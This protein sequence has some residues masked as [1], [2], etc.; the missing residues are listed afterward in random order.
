VPLTVA[1][2]TNLAVQRALLAL[3]ALITASCAAS[4]ALTGSPEP[5]EEQ[6]A[7]NPYSPWGRPG[8]AAP[9]T[10]TDSPAVPRANL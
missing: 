6:T 3:A 5:V 8:N 4:M 7:A 10:G 9:T 1:A 2:L